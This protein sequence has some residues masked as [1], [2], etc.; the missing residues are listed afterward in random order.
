MQLTARFAWPFCVGNVLISV[1][2]FG[3][4]KRFM[5]GWYHIQKPT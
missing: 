3:R 4:K 5:A 2:T 1:G